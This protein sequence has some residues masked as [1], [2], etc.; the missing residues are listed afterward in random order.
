MCDINTRG[1]DVEAN[2]NKGKEW[3][4]NYEEEYDEDKEHEETR[5]GKERHDENWKRRRQDVNDNELL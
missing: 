2:I 5:S 4:W 1:K 3:H